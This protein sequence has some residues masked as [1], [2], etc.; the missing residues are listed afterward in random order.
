V[1]RFTKPNAT[2]ASQYDGAPATGRGHRS[3][4]GLVRSEH[5]VRR[6]RVKARDISDWV[7]RVSSTAR[8]TPEIPRSRCRDATGVAPVRTPSFALTSGVHPQLAIDPV[9]LLLD[10]RERDCE[11]SG[12]LGHGRGLSE[13]AQ[14]RAFT[15][16][17][18]GASGITG[19]ERRPEE[20]FRTSFPTGACG[21][22]AGSSGQRHGTAIRGDSCCRTHQLPRGT[23]RAALNGPQRPG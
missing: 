21:A 13:T 5:G 4:H 7:R 20:G 11:G 8:P 9:H 14:H 12:E 17:A 2:L 16:V 3:Q 10:S 1:D 18:I 19:P 6:R 15:A 22:R 23:A